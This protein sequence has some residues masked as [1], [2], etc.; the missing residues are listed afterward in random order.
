MLSKVCALLIAA[1]LKVFQR[2]KVSIAFNLNEIIRTMRQ[3]SIQTIINVYESIDSLPIS[4]KALMQHAEEMAKKAYAPYSGFLVGAS[5]LLSNGKQCGGHNFENAAY[6]MCLC[7]ERAAL[8]AARSQYP[9]AKV[10]AIAIRVI[11]ASEEMKEPA[12]PCG[13]CRQVLCETEDLH[14]QPIRVFMQGAGSMIYEVASAR[15]LLPLAFSGKYLQP[16]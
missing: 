7:G 15:D 14:Q 1:N 16:K 4:I 8:A 5:V 9:E 13:A 6:P 11:G 2:K 12:S 10:E 3:I